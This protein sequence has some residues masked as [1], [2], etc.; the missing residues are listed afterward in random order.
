MIKNKSNSEVNTNLTDKGS[1]NPIGL[2]NTLSNKSL[3]GNQTLLDEIEI[4]SK[5]LVLNSNFK[6]VKKSSSA[7]TS[8][9]AGFRTTKGYNPKR[10]D[11]ANQ[12]RILITSKFN[13]ASNQWVFWVFDG[14][15][16]DGHLVSQFVRDNICSYILKQK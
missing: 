9:Y 1:R 10:P 3:K 15:G 11:K 5:K 14:H 13:N 7:W 16:T 8:I 2:L 6:E 4:K 12:D